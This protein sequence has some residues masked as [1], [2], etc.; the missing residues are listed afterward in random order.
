[1]IRRE[2][3]DERAL[4]VWA[5]TDAA[6]RRHSLAELHSLAE[7]AGLEVVDTLAQHIKRS[8]A[9]TRL[10]KGKVE[11]LAALCRQ[12][13]VDVVVFDDPLTPA[14][15]RNLE[16]AVDTKVI[17]RSQLILDIFASRA[18]TRAGKLQVELA[19]LEYLLP[20]LTRHWTHLSRLGGGVGTR[21]PG[22]TQLEVDRRQVRDKIHR[23]RNRLREIDRTRRL[24]RA[25]REAVPYPS[26]ALVGYTNAGKS[27]LLN[28]LTGAD[29]YV[30]DQL[31]ATLDSTVR[32]LDLP[33]RTTAML[34]DTVGF[35]AKLPHE[36]IAAF[37]GTLEHVVAAD[38]ILH[39]V[40]GSDTEMKQRIEVVRNIL[41]ELQAGANES[42]LV[43][44]KRDLGC[45]GPVPTGAV[46][47]SARTGEGIT[48]LLERIDA[49][50]AKQRR[51][52]VVTLP[53]TDGR[54]RS[55]L[56][57]Y[58]RV[59]EEGTEPDTGEI[60]IVAAIDAK[61]AGRLAAMI[62]NGSGRLMYQ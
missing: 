56:Y 19:Q 20:R 43:C 35:V 50:L 10:G 14:Q 45:P 22:E 30:A 62:R 41:A 39:V 25:D 9:A 4:L 7:S 12:T 28:R 21:G 55:W 31:F 17:D 5:G 53:A 34:A 61:A 23:L 38:L 44:N 58:A 26:V 16:R 6:V 36:L 32:R 2:V 29:I 57:R 11:E 42:I 60:R 47:V 54:T 48:E 52:V 27:S 3:C 46:G 15:R 49:V 59:L 8:T 40:D 37:K 1:V 18:R 51:K 33:S 24:N 13:G